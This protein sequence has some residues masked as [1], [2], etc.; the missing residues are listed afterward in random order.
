MSKTK[1]TTLMLELGLWTVWCHD[2]TQG[3]TVWV[4]VCVDFSFTK[5]DYRPQR[6]VPSDAQYY[7]NSA[8]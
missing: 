5:R 7:L 8:R 4:G 1:T 3:M 2:L 6:V